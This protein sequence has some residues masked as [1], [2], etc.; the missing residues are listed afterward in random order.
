MYVCVYIYIYIYVYIYIYIHVC[1]TVI[2]HAG[3]RGKA[4]K[5]QASTL[6]L[7]AEKKGRGSMVRA[8]TFHEDGP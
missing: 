3:V 7:R 1:K 6:P 4:A 5:E 2:R 8:K